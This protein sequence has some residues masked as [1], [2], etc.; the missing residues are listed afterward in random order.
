MVEEHVLPE[1]ILGM[2]DK[3]NRTPRAANGRSLATRLKF[4]ANVQTGCNL[5]L[6]EVFKYHERCTQ[7]LIYQLFL[8]PSVF[9]N[10]M[11]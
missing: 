5:F 4:C 10:A 1:I 11:Q 6:D 8:I 3:M 9:H 7:P 2:F